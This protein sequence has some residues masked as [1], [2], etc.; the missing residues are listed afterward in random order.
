MHLKSTKFALLAIC[1]LF[2]CNAVKANG[3][4]T[5]NFKKNPWNFINAKQGDEP[6]L[7]SLKMDLKLKKKALLS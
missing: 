7:V 2:I 6:T 5:F 3:Y 1:M 4:V